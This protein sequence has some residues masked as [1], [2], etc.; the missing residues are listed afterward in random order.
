VTPDSRSTRQLAAGNEVPVEVV[1]LLAHRCPKSLLEATEEGWISGPRCSLA[2]GN[3][4]VQ[5]VQLLADCRAASLKVEEEGRFF[6]LHLYLFVLKC[7]S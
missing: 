2:L 3:E 4:P 6:R 7:A 1:R 5:A